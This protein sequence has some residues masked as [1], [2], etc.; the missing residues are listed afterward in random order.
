M[1]IYTNLIYSFYL[2]IDK[3][4]LTVFYLYRQ[5]HYNEHFS[6]PKGDHFLIKISRKLLPF[7]QT[8]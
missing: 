7:F 1:L 2:I 5:I 4:H 3:N 8:A 6:Y